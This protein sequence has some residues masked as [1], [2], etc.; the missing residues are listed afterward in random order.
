VIAKRRERIVLLL[1]LALPAAILAACGS[2]DGTGIRFWSYV[3]AWA[4]VDYD[5]DAGSR[6]YERVDALA[7][8]ESGY[9]IFP[10]G[11]L[12]V[13]H[14]EYAG[15]DFPTLME[16]EGSWTEEEDGDLLFSYVYGAQ[17]RLLR[18]EI[19]DIGKSEMECLETRVNW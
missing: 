9:E 7:A 8:N 6:I 12:N 4:F 14:F 13:L 16:S 11:M 17:T 19:L 1:A 2:D 15:G 18:V 10:G 5:P 3:G